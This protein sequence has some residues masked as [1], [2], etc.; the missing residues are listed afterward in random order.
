MSGPAGF[1]RILSAA[2]LS[3]LLAGLILTGVQ[4]VQVSP[5]IA[6]AEAYE[7]AASAAAERHAASAPSSA[8]H[9]HHDHG[10]DHSHGH[11]NWQPEDGMERTFFTAL[12]NISVAVGFALLLGAA[13][14]LRG[15]VSGWR[16]G[17]LWGL[18][19]YTVFFIAPSLG[20][21]PQVPGTEAAALPDR[22]LWWLLTTI[23]TAAALS[24]SVFARRWSA[25][26]AAALLLIVPYLVGAPEPQVY[27]SSAPAEL[28]LA[29]IYATAIANGVLWI[30]LGGLM[31]F[32]Y[33]RTR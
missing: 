12:S 13:I 30:A 27:S 11:G 25:K 24:L 15:G 22:Q 10:H 14:H 9:A 19:G 32:F 20:L 31:G 23:C 4:K 3:G 17:L 6:M 21:P 33:Q 8:G 2:A 29:F 28:S 5:I 7:E 16:A 18:A 1:K 26:P